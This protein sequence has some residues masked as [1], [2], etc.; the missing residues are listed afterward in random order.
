[1]DEEQDI[2]QALIEAERSLELLKERYAQVS[3]DQQRLQDTQR[4]LRR[5]EQQTNQRSSPALKADIK[6]LKTQIDELE[7]AL[8]S[9]LFSWRGLKESFWQAIRF[10]LLGVVVGWLLKSC[11]S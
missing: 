10:G 2:G 3:A 6:Q 4:D 8:E 1:M 5:A 7:L 9:R 11:A